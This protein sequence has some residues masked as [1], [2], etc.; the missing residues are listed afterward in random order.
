MRR[1]WAALSASLLLV[2]FSLANAKQPERPNELDEASWSALKAVAGGATQQ[3]R[4]MASDGSGGSEFGWSVALSGDTALVGAHNANAAYV[5]TRNGSIW[6][7]QQKLVAPDP[8]SSLEFGW[9][10]ALSGDTALVGDRVARVDGTFKGAVHV[11]T[12]SGTTW[13]HAARLAAGCQDCS[14]SMRS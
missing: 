14:S 1:H 10:V 2:A 11:Y 8:G 5:Y 3:Q 9:S 13:T 4:L 6:T 12:R 7:E